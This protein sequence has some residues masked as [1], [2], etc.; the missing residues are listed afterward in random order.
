VEKKYTAREA[1]V[2]VLKKAEELLK[3]WHKKID[4]AEGAYKTASQV[5]EFKGIPQEKPKMG[6]VAKPPR[7]L[8]TFMAKK[9]A[10]RMAKNGQK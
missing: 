2:E 6:M 4:K 9:E 1:A 3:N 5:G 8:K 7:P 10:K